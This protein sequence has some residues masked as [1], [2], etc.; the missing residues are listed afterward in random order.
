MRIHHTIALM[1]F[2]GAAGLLYP[3][4]APLAKQDPTEAA[5]F[6][7]NAGDYGRAI[8]L[9]TDILQN[10]RLD[11]PVLASVYQERGIARHKSGQS[12]QAIADYTNAIWL[13]TLSDPELARTLLDRGIAY[14]EVGELI[15]ARHDFDN[16]IAKTP[17]LAD[18]Y[19]GRATVVR[20]LGRP[21]DSVADYTA[22]L[23]LSHPA[24]ALIYFGR[25]L[26]EEAM[27]QADRALADFTQAAREA[28][29]FAPAKAKLAQLG[30]PFP[31][32]EEIDAVAL[33]RARHPTE[34]PKDP[35][36]SLALA[37]AG[38]VLTIAG[39]TASEPTGALPLPVPSAPAAPGP[40]TVL[41]SAVPPASQPS[42]LRPAR[43]SLL[44]QQALAANDQIAPPADKV[45]SAVPSAAPAAAAP[46]PVETAK[47]SEDATDAAAPTGALPPAP[48]LPAAT[49]ASPAPVQP[50]V[51]P[52]VPAPAKA[53]GAKTG[54]AYGLQLAAYGDKSLAER[55]AA[56]FSARFPAV[57]SA[58]PPIVEIA[59]VGGRA[60]YR[61]RIGAFENEDQSR[62][63]CAA[64]KAKSQA[65]V[66]VLPTRLPR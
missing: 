22:A 36:S 58:H 3:L 17:Q 48:S 10:E 12:L 41:S 34:T 56:A 24:P 43:D 57:A 29:Y 11:P 16:A 47:T 63:A 59:K 55:A 61:L 66:L 30:A 45:P 51:K 54:G 27:G 19:F 21:A 35:A 7:L 44:A 25:G 6:A 2:L 53:E 15:R 31:S 60:L 49:D 38:D 32:Q 4:V 18:A 62:S 39:T 14:V 1:S 46:P 23:R 5:R 42:F 40:P 65:C 26:A 50:A 37:E 20:L 28:P 9:Y 52:E 8:S 64:L 13:G 33:D